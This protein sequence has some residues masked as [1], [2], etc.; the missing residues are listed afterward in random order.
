LELQRFNTRVNKLRVSL[1]FSKVESQAKMHA[2]PLIKAVAR[3]LCIEMAP[4]EQPTCNAKGEIEGMT[5][6]ELT[7]EH[8]RLRNIPRGQ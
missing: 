7:K 4:S 5:K 6:D 3:G 1:G 2:P 8:E